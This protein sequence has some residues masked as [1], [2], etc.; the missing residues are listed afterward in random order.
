MVNCAYGTK[1]MWE[2]LMS[3]PQ[4]WSLRWLGV[5]ICTDASE[6]G[7][8]LA[9]REGCRE[10]A[11]EVGR[12]AERTRFKR[13]SMSIGARSHALRFM[14]PDVALECSSSDQDEV[15]LT[16]KERVA[17][18]SGSVATASGSLGMEIG[19]VRWFLLRRK[20]LSS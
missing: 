11:S 18:T 14:A 7:C 12:V 6:K 17:R 3:S 1:S 13:S 19:G 16:R 4:C 9:V 5:C 2:N 8:A 20:H 15:S 10:L